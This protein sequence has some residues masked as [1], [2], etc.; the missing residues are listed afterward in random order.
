ME[1]NAFARA[2]QFLYYSRRSTGAALLASFGLGLAFVI[3]LTVTFLMVELV[4]YQGRLWDQPEGR[5]A[6]EAWCARWL[7]ERIDRV[8]VLNAHDGG[9]GVGLV[10]LAVRN[11]DV[12]YGDAFASM[13][14][15]WSWTR[16]NPSYLAGLVCVFLAAGVF[17]IILALGL[18][19]AATHSV[20]EAAH[21]LRRAVYLHTLRLGKLS[22]AGSAGTLPP[23]S[24]T[25]ELDILQDGLYAWL[26]VTYKEPAKLILVFGFALALDSGTG[27]PWLTVLGVLFALLL[28]L[29]GGYIAQAAR[30]QDRQH[31]LAAAEQTA[32][33]QESLRIMRLVVGFSLETFNG[34]RVERQ[35]AEHTAHTRRRLMARMLLRQLLL[36]LGLVSAAILL[37]ALGWGLLNGHLRLSQTLVVAFS[38]ASLYRPLRLLMERQRLVTVAERAA[39]PIYR[40]LETE[41]DVRQVVGAEFLPPMARELTVHNVS[42]RD[43]VRNEPLLQNVTFQLAAGEKV[44]LVGESQREKL[45]LACLLPRL[46]DPTEGEIRIDGRKLP[47]V[48]LESLR[49]QIALILQDDLVFTDSVRNNIGG[50]DASATLPRVIEAA[51]VAHAHQFIQKLPNGYDTVIGDLGYSLRHSEKYRIALARAILHDPSLVILE[52]PTELYEEDIRSL[53]EDTMT[54]FLTSRTVIYLAHRIAT[55]RNVSR[56]L[57]FHKG[58][59]E[60]AGDHETLLQKSDR[61]RHMIYLEYNVFADQV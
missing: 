55:I 40:F 41:G 36:L 18:H 17:H 38:L 4:V 23:P 10:S 5:R 20:T 33:L 27:W 59:I 26:T 29:V 2:R 56:V 43:P 25:R 13:A 12:W 21:R 8:E 45:A 31:A 22:L 39:E 50:G 47:W 49:N 53:L 52:E 16:K 7:P 51:K 24:Y 54:R 1:R 34:S 30:K 9:Y 37:Y 14:A 61:Y 6:L 42:L 60:A 58:R 46:L 19:A 32:L 48:T 28:W 35:L 15:N 11:R 3:F 44:A 57:F